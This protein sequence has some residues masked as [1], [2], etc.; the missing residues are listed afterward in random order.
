MSR[1]QVRQLEDGE[2]FKVSNR[3]DHRDIC[4]ECGL[5]HRTEYKFVKGKLVFRSWQVKKRKKKSR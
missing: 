2:W 1:W 4:C 3:K 5:E